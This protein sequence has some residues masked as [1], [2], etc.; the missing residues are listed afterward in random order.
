VN[1]FNNQRA[2][3]API[4]MA[5]PNSLSAV[6]RAIVRAEILAIMNQID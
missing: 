2:I 1:N 4:T 5:D 3:N 6:Q